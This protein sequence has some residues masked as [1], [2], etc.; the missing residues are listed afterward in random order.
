MGL[1]QRFCSSHLIF[2]MCLF[3]SK[4]AGEPIAAIDAIDAGKASFLQH[5]ATNPNNQ[6]TTYH[7]G[8]FLASSFLV[9]NKS[10]WLLDMVEI[11]NL[12]EI[13]NLFKWQSSI[14]LVASSKKRQCYKLLKEQALK[15]RLSNRVQV[16]A[17][18]DVTFLV[19]T[20]AASS[21]INT[22]FDK[23]YWEKSNLNDVRI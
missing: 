6:C 7:F 18:I 2:L 15:K 17:T 16:V 19:V 10:T 1:M 13:E 11:G 8:H 3:C 14:C 5:Q 23:L 21:L 9:L 12:L 20:F 4:E 22:H